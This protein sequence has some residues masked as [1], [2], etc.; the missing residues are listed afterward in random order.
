MYCMIC[1]KELKPVLR[2]TVTTKDKSSARWWSG[3]TPT[4]G[5]L[6]CR[7]EL[8]VNLGGKVIPLIVSFSTENWEKW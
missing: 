4:C 1:G 5:N 2:E 7:E 8:I 6:H 3:V